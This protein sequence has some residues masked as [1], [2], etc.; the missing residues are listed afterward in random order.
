[1]P[2]SVCVKTK[3]LKTV[4][5]SVTDEQRCQDRLRVCAPGF[6]LIIL[7][8]FLCVFVACEPET[9]ERIEGR[10]HTQGGPDKLV[11]TGANG[12]LAKERLAAHAAS[13]AVATM[14][15]RVLVPTLDALPP[16]VTFDRPG[17]RDIL[18]NNI[19]GLGRLWGFPRTRPV[20]AEAKRVSSRLAKI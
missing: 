1:M 3:T 15:V 13:P 4:E 12:G 17:V 7:C 8:A 9:Y 20:G 2:K 5:T 10:T 16:R 18:V 11:P 19:K 14:A 6:G